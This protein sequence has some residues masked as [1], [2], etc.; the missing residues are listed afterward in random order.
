MHESKGATGI[1]HPSPCWQFT[2]SPYRDGNATT[3]RLDDKNKKGPHVQVQ[4]QTKA[5][6]D[7]LSIGAV[8]STLLGWLPG[9]AAIFTILWTGIRIWETRTVQG[10]LK[11]FRK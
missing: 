8:V 1:A 10:W 11:R 3:K 2:P 4:E 5:V 9:I 6:V 7:V